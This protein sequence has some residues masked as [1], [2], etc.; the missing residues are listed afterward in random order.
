M[1]D[2]HHF[3]SWLRLA[4]VS[5]VVGC[6]PT[7]QTPAQE[8]EVAMKDAQGRAVGLLRLRDTS[9]GV[10]ISGELTGLPPGLHAFHIH[11]TGKCEAPTFESAGGHLNYGGKKHGFDNPEGFH[12]GDLP[13]VHVS[14]AG[15]ATVETFATQVRLAVGGASL[16]DADGSALVVH[17][18]ADDHRTDPAGAAGDRIACGVIPAR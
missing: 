15:T 17:A 14:T 6:T 3:T 13:N 11:T 8:V 9:N 18:A 12:A 5:I 4:L 1:D 16:T 7:T 10:R 2:S